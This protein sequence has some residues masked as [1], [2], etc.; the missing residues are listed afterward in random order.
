MKKNLY[1][2]VSLLTLLTLWGCDLIGIVGS[3]DTVVNEYTFTDFNSV[4]A[5]YACDVT[6]S[7]GS[8]YS[9]TITI[10]DNIESYLDIRKSDNMLH[11]DLKSGYSYHNLNFKADIVMPDLVY[12]KLSGA[13]SAEVTGFERSGEFRTKLSGASKA[14]LDFLSVGQIICDLSGAS[15]LDFSTDSAD[16]G[17]EIDCSGASKIDINA[18]ISS[19]DV[20]LDCSGAS[21]VNLKDFTA[22]NADISISGASKIY[23]K[24]NGNLSGSASG[25]SGLYYRGNLQSINVDVSGASTLA[26]Y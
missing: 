25:A 9:I 23:I 16:A 10:D 1:L 18:S 17:L 13:S 2:T 8:T 14:D 24:M 11:V 26:E 4:N 21:E 7:R 6:I 20:S 3:G 15:D 12:L 19:A 5:A 22:N